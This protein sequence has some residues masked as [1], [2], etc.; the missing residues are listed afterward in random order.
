MIDLRGACGCRGENNL[1]LFD[2]IQWL[3]KFD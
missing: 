2:A 3:S 1:V